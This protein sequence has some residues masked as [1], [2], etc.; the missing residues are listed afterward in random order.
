MNR[1]KPPPPRRAVAPPP[2]A[3]RAARARGAAA[4]DRAG[5]GAP[6]VR[7]RNGARPRP[8]P[9][10][11]TEWDLL[12]RTTQDEVEQ[13]VEVLKAVK[14]G[15]FTVRLPYRSDGIL[16]RAG[17]LLNDIIGL[18]EHMANELLRV[19]RRSSGRRGA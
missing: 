14:A 8:P 16:S 7:A 1:A 5:A 9:D 19:G 6:P 10:A 18:N 12:S 13:L 2:S 17:E 15:D 3:A 11:L 4:G